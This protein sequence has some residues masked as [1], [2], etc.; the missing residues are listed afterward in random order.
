MFQHSIVG[1]DIP[2][3]AQTGLLASEAVFTCPVSGLTMQRGLVQQWSI[4][5]A[6]PVSAD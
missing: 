4:L 1:L 2:L 3:I 5:D 6:N